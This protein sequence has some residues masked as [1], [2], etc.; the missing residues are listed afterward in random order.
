MELNRK[1]KGGLRVR[2]EA[3]NT[4]ELDCTALELELPERKLRRVRISQK[5]TRIRVYEGNR[6]GFVLE[7]DFGSGR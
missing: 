2:S 5:D 7:D 6:L 3:S 4:K 1:K